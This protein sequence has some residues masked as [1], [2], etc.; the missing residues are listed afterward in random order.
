[1]GIRSVDA[2]RGLVRWCV[3][4]GALRAVFF[5]QVPLQGHALAERGYGFLH[6]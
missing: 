1:M 2:S 4:Y 3:K 5:K 6:H